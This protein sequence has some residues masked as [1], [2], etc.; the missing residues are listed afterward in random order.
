MDYSDKSVAVIGV[1]SS[2]IQV[3]P[4]LQPKTKQVDNYVRGKTWV[5]TPFASKTLLAINPSGENCRLPFLLCLTVAPD[6]SIADQFT[7]ADKKRFQDPKEYFEF[8]LELERELNSVHGATLKGHPMQEGGRVAFKEMMVKKLAKKPWIA[9]HII[10]DFPVACRRLTP[11]PGYLEALV[12]DNVDFIP[13]HISHVTEDGI[14]TVD[15][16]SRKYDVIVCATGYDTTYKPEIDIVG[17]SGQ[18]LADQ[19]SPDPIAYLGMATDGFPNWF[20][21]LGP[22]NAVGSG[23]LLCIIERQI[24]YVVAAAKKVQRERIKRIEVKKAAIDDYDEYMRAYFPKT[25]YS[26]KC[27]SWCTLVSL[28]TFHR[29]ADGRYSTVDKMGKEE[30]RVF[31]LWPGSCLHALR[32][33]ERPRWEDYDYELLDGKKNRF[34]WLGDGWSDAEKNGNGDGACHHLQ[35]MTRRHELIFRVCL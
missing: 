23:S 11:G 25:V 27:R 33:L 31:G 29:F 12:S 2:A 4:A 16:K 19:W 22:N 34:Y 17:R 28:A 3:V 21:I 13:T 32:A 8:R 5:A 30:G 18:T 35:T 10:P 26:D 24:D 9:D 7:A 15:G 1:G 14:T 6:V 20:N